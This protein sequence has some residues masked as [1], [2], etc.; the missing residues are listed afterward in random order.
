MS[1]TNATFVK[2]GRTGIW[3]V[4]K[5]GITGETNGQLV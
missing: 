3:E 1:K 4:T 2:F 5:Q